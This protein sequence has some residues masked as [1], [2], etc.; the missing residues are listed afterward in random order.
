MLG[1]LVFLN[2]ESCGRIWYKKKAFFFMVMACEHSSFY[3]RTGGDDG[4]SAEFEFLRG[5]S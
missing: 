2:S 5:T 3:Q 1:P 4:F